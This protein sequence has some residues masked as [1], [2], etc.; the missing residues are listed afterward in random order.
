M[1]EDRP[2]EV[3]SFFL[4]GCTSFDELD[5]PQ[6]QRAVSSAVPTAAM[7]AFGESCRRR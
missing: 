4:L 5:A 3:S 2:G 6:S 1:A 7:A